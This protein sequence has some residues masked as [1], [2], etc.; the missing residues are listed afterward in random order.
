[1]Q[2]ALLIVIFTM[3]VFA[4]SARRLSSTIIT[5]PVVFLVLGLLIHFFGVIPPDYSEELLHLIAEIALII[6]LFVDASLIDFNALKKRYVWPKR[7]LLIGLPLAVLLCT[8]VTMFLFPSWPILAAALAAAILA[9]TDAALS[10]AVVSNESVPIEERRTLVVES[11]LNDGLALPII[12]FFACTLST[13][14]GHH[15]SN[16]LIFTAKQLIL[17]PAVGVFLGW[18][19]GKALLKSI[20]KNLTSP[21]FEGIAAIAIAI[22]AYLVAHMV[23]GNGFIAA[24]CAGL[25]FG[26]VA[27]SRVKHVSEFVESEG[28]LLIWS[29]FL[30]IGL[31][32]LPEALEAFNLQI[33]LLIGISIFIVRPLAIWLSLIGTDAPPLTRLFLGWFG[34]RGLATA[35][36]ALL[37]VGD[38]NQ[39]YAEP[40]LMI[41]INAVWISALLHG[42]SAA[43]AAKWF[44][45]KRAK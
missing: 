36:F 43:P 19:G 45:N 28:Q 3:A 2:I 9:P 5:A 1:M 44:G 33:G 12:L 26:H 21:E 31:V 7:M 30:L 34:P 22:A 16:F 15:D 6:L 41:A 13:I 27:K 8:G 37:V 20:D 42:M 10:Q 17:G 4:L 11:G 40:V 35:L 18:L 32:L 29:S 39:T 23:D 38:I 14:Q 25:A 24:F